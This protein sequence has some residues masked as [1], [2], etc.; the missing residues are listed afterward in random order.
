MPGRGPADPPR[1]GAH[2]SVQHGRRDPEQTE[3]VDSTVV[4]S[5][6]QP[7][8]V[9][10]DTQ[11]N[12]R[13]AGRVGTGSQLG[14]HG[15]PGRAVVADHDLGAAGQPRVGVAECRRPVAQVADGHRSVQAQLSRDPPGRVGVAVEPHDLVRAAAGG[16]V[17][18]SGTGH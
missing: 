1:A 3:S 7:T 17:R 6:D 11:P 2:V 14:A 9:A 16:I 18:S 13:R 4:G 12:Q 10:V 8:T 15:L 5:D